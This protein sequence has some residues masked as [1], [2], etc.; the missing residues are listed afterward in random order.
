MKILLL[1]K[2]QKSKCL[3]N[4]QVV[5]FLYL[6]ILPGVPVITNKFEYMVT[7]MDSRVL[8][9]FCDLVVTNRMT[10]LVT[11]KLKLQL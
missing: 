5:I 1:K 4:H 8:F 2:Y 11:E 7:D 6:Y 9:N 3:K 10:T